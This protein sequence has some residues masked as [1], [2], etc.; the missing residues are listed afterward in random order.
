MVNDFLEARQFQENYRSSDQKQLTT[1][2]KYK[3]K[4]WV[5]TLQSPGEILELLGPDPE[6]E[7]P[8]HGICRIG[9]A[10][11]VCKTDI[12]YWNEIGKN[13]VYPGG[14]SKADL[15]S[16]LYIEFA[17]FSSAGNILYVLHREISLVMLQYLTVL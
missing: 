15:R 11:Q 13:Y 17:M 7:H 8:A 2:P 1:T 5:E 14:V 9:L 4:N 6:S 3:I 12:Y 10:A 16:E